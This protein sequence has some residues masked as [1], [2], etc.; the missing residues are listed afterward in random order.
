VPEEVAE[1]KSEL[2]GISEAHDILRSVMLPDHALA[3]LLEKGLEPTLVQM[4]NGRCI[5]VDGNDMTSIVEQ[6]WNDG[7]IVS[8]RVSEEKTHKEE[9]YIF[10]FKYE[11]Y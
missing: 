5:A 11:E 6:A 7:C 1:R 3:K 10:Y 4:E 9:Y 8:G 2:T